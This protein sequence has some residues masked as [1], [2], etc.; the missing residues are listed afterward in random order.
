MKNH[1]KKII[2]GIIVLIIIG[3]VWYKFR[4][5]NQEEVESYVIEKGSVEK[6]LS[7]SGKIEPKE[8]VDLSFET[9]ALV[10]WVDVEIGDKVEKGQALMRLDKSSLWANVKEAQ[11]AVEKAVAS[12]QLARR[13]WELYKP[14]EKEQFKKTS[15]QARLNLEAVKAQYY[16]GTLNSPIDGVV[17]QVN[18]KEGEVAQG[19]V[20]RIINDGNNFEVEAEVSEADIAEI[21]VGQ[22]AEVTFDAF[23]SD[24]KFSAKVS[25]IDPEAKD[26]QDVV[27]FRVLFELDKIDERTR[28]GMTVDVDILSS[29]KDDVLVVPLRFVRRDDAGSYV[30]VKKDKEEKQGF[31]AKKSKAADN[32]E[33]R[34]VKTGI[35]S[36]DGLMEIV[37]GVEDGE[38]VVL[39]YED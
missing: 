27:Y 7:V 28:S 23:T 24:E 11:V 21:F 34:Y 33:K 37:D 15:E 2:I 26:I 5:S 9:P 32:A 14:E 38:K 8:Y 31:F 12:E 6:T 36:D 13:N 22:E 3:I 19:V 17:T 20:V 39:I 35:E 18:A 25:Q 1:K 29:Q 10:S 16:K 4:S 30:F